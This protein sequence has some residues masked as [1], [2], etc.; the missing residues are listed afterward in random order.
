[1]KKTITVNTTSVYEARSLAELVGVANGFSSTIIL[2]M[3]EKRINAKSI[4]GVMGI[5]IDNGSVVTIEAE[6]QDA[7]AAISAIE[8]FLTR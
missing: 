7:E 4:M 6:G 2:V 8:D 3:E 5:G 1:M